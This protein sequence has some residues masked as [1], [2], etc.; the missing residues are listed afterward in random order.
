VAVP[1]PSA[2]R[3]MGL[4]MRGWRTTSFDHG[5]IADQQQPFA[6]GRPQHILVGRPE[7]L[8]SSIVSTSW[9][10]ELKTTAA[11]TGNSRRD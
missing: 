2:R 5:L 1:V 9:T 4:R 6:G 10:R 8:S 7:H 11:S 3:V